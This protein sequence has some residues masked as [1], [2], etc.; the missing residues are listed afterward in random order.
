M[1]NET[2]KYAETY[3]GMAGAVLPLIIMM[4]TMIFMVAFGMRS[5]KN[6]WSAGYFAV[7]AG[8]LVYKDKKAFQKALI[9]GVR[10]NIFAFMIACFLF[11]GVMSKI[12]TA[13]HLIE[14][15]LYVMTKINMSPAL[16]PIICFFIC[17][18]LSSATGSAAGALN[19]AGPL[20][21]PL[22]VGMGCNVNLICGAILAGSCF[23]DNLAP[24]SDTTI[25]SSLSQ[26]VDVMKV[27]RSRFKYALIAGAISVVGYLVCGF[28]DAGNGV[29]AEMAAVDA[30]YASSIVFLIIPVLVV[31][32][33]L[34][35]S[36]LF[37]SLRACQR[38]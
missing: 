24:I 23:G 21:I 30:T 5:T 8:F 22:S 37:T 29:S 11:A 3:G 34:R 18:V 38:T 6:F 17:V 31:V 4:G 28:M 35:G 33:T 20:L 1:I 13:S 36:G 10:D 12:L 7:L 2:K 9:N 15:L 32:L 16:M 26:E 14:A 25:A 19:T 27:V